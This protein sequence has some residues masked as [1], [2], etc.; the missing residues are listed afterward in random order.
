MPLTPNSMKPVLPPR[1]RKGDTIGLFCPAGPVRD[2]RAFEGGINLIKELGFQVKLQGAFQNND[3]YLA[4]GDA[5]RAQNFHALW[6]DT[7][8]QAVMAIRGGFGSVRMME[9]IELDRLQRNPKMLIGF[10]DVSALISGMISHANLVA[11]HGP[12]VTSLTLH[13]QQSVH[14]L[15]SLLTG[16]AEDLIAGKGMEIL[17]GGNRRGR[18]MGGNLTTLVH[19]IG[20]PWDSSWENAL[21]VLEDTGESLYRLDR[22]LTQLAFSGRLDRLAGLILGTFDPGNSDRL[23]TLR[24]QEQVWQRALELTQRFDFPVW[25]N[26]PVGHQAANFALPMGMEATMDSQTGKLRLHTDSV[27]VL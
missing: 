21:L 15:F 9:H 16:E 8:V 25:A 17:R 6:E 13:D 14:Q 5:A 1:L 7:R 3:N 19:L 10:S 22:M 4:D 26:F 24:L 11:V 20:T 27:Q 12:V 2:I 23:E 18:I